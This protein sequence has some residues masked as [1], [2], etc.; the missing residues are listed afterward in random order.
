MPA[1]GCPATPLGQVARR[2]A[3]DKFLSALRRGNPVD[4]GFLPDLRVIVWLG[5]LSRSATLVLKR[6]V[7]VGRP[8]SGRARRRVISCER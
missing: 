8:V 4:L 1:V 5:R 3:L 2:A 7:C 6:W